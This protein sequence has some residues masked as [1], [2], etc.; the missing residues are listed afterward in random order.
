ME[1]LIKDEQTY[2]IPSLASH[3]VLERH[4]EATDW[5]SRFLVSFRT[6]VQP[7]PIHLPR[8]FLLGFWWL[9]YSP[10]NL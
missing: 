8:P 10:L 9:L 5:A 2:N 3:Y 6:G 4:C 7:A 1:T